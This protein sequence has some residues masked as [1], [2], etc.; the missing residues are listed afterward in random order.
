MTD[1]IKLKAD[2]FVNDKKLKLNYIKPKDLKLLLAEFCEEQIAELKA[3]CDLAIEGRDVQIW[4]LEKENEKLKGQMS[5]H[6]GLLWNDLHKLEKELEEEKKLNAEIKA[7]F[8]KCNTCTDEMKSKC[9]M[10]SENLCEGERCE[11]LVDLM[12]LISKSELEKENA[13]LKKE[14]NEWKSEWQEQV[15]K[16]TDE[17]YARTLQTIQLSKAKDLLKWF[18]WYFREG[19]PN[20]VPYKH[21]VEEAEQFLKDLEK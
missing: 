19:S 6:E 18:V 13:S 1:K 4:E 21:K 5:L 14:L 2:K 15:Q 9:L 8:V 7:R 10:F 20:L 16:A 3:E 12:G 17:E 11:E